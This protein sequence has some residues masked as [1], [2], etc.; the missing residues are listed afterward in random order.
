MRFIVF[1]SLLSLLHNSTFAQTAENFQAQEVNLVQLSTQF[2]KDSLQENRISAAAEF[3]EAL[4]ATLQQKASFNYPFAALETVSI[5]YPPDSTFRIFTWQIYVD[6]ADYRYGG[7]IQVNNTDNQIFPLEDQSAEVADYDL[8]FDV[9][10]PSDWYGAVYF[11]I[12]EYDTPKGKQYLLFGFDGFQFFSKRKLVEAFYFDETGQP[13]FGAPAFAKTAQGYEASTKNRLYLEY[14][15]EVAAR[16]NYDPALD[17]IILDNLVSMRSPYRGAGNVNIPDGSY[18]G[19]QLNNGV[20]EHVEKVFSLVS[21]KPPAPRRVFNE[22]NSQ[23]DLFGKAARGK[24]RDKNLPLK[25][26]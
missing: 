15:S 2:L 7:I 11:N 8:E 17:M 10:G 20:W 16:L 14:S 3:N 21:E 6:K 24:K 9:L 19:Y 18:I 1:I 23:K 22:K 12:H 5:L 4:T 26:R 13:V 25:N